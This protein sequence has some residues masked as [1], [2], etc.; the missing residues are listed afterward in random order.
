MAEARGLYRGR[1]S[2]S[3]FTLRVSSVSSWFRTSF[4]IFCAKRFLAASSRR[5][6]ERT[7]ERL[8][9]PARERAARRV[10]EGLHRRAARVPRPDELPRAPD[11]VDERRAL[12]VGRSPMVRPVSLRDTRRSPG[13]P[14]SSQ[15]STRSSGARVPGA[16]TSRASPLTM[17]NVDPGLSQNEL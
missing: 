13:P 3:R 16:G 11:E 4:A 12:P 15:R 6:R 5:G 9:R 2:S 17:V 8:R 10:E 1:F 14:W 7:L